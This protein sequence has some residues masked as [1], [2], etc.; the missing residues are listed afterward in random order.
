M[1]IETTLREVDRLAEAFVHTEPVP[2]LAYGV[3]VGGRLIHTR[4][5][6][7]T[8]VGEDAS[9]TENTIFRIASMTKSFTAATV[10]QLRDGGHLR[11]DDLASAHVPELDAGRR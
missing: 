8:R 3:L 10:L 6:G 7:T 9:P 5:L 1:A 4:G 2:G 11:L